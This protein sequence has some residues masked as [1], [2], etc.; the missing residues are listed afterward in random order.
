MLLISHRVMAVAQ[1]RQNGGQQGDSS[2]AEDGQAWR[3]VAAARSGFPWSMHVSMALVTAAAFLFFEERDS[4]ALIRK[5]VWSIVIPVRRPAVTFVCLLA[6]P[7]PHA[8]HMPVACSVSALTCHPVGPLPGSLQGAF[9][10]SA[11][12]LPVLSIPHRQKPCKSRH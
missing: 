2:A 7:Q 1:L 8:L 11:S 4:S 12:G 10:E 9:R 3:V 5:L 6:C